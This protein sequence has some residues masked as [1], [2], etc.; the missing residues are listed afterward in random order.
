MI[1]RKKGLFASKKVSICST[2]AIVSVLT[3]ACILQI[4]GNAQAASLNQVLVR[5]DR[6]KTSTQTTGT[7]CAKAATTATEA[8]VEVVFPTSY[9]LGA[10]ASFTVNTTNLAWPSGGTAWPSITTATN[11]TSQTVTFPSGD[12]TVGT[13][14]CFNWANTAAVQTKSSATSS[15]T[16]TVT[17]K[18][19]VSAVIDTATYAT[20]TISDDQISVSASV[21]QAFSFALSGNTDVLGAMSTG[22]VTTSPTP[23]TVTINTN[24]KNGWMVWAKDGSAGLNSP[25]A[26]Y[27]LASTTPGTNSTL[28]SGT[29]GYNFGVTGTQGGGSGTLAVAAPFVGSAAG[30]GGGLD[31]TQ[32]LITSSNGTASNAVMTLKNNAAIGSL[33]PA[34]SDYGDVVTI[35]GAGLF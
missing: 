27:T 22:T 13:L 17:T 4:T 31:T 10:A 23:R 7:I 34:A 9:T 5:F 32:R 18:D 14:Y 30:Q 25:T 35:I 11:V 29:E 26:S 20:A 12:L 1:H 8:S 33:T 24:S 28:S 6:M 2:F 3:G 15:N 16:G 19:G 21:P